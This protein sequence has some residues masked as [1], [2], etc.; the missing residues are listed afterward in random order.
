MYLFSLKTPPKRNLRSFFFF[1]VS[2]RLP[3]SFSPSLVVAVSDL[4]PLLLIIVLAQVHS[5]YHCLR[6]SCSFFSVLSVVLLLFAFII[7][8]VVILVVVCLSHEF[9]WFILVAIT[10]LLLFLKWPLIDFVVMWVWRNILGAKLSISYDKLCMYV[11]CNCEKICLERR[12][13]FIIGQ[14]IDADK[15][16]LTI[17]PDY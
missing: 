13:M 12:L 3:N 15:P 10:L 4:L 2:Q 7:V 11:C 16:L 1:M 6:H 8:H 14:L 5:S 9:H 17:I